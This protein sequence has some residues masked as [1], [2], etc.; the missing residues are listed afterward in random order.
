MFVYCMLSEIR[1]VAISLLEYGLWLCK[2][3]PNPK[4]MRGSDMTVVIEADSRSI[5]HCSP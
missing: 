1:S 3:D 2:L 5:G 4:H